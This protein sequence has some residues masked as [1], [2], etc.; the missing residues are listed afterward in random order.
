LPPYC[1]AKANSKGPDDPNFAKWRGT[2]GEAYTHIHHY[3]SGLYSEQKAGGTI[4]QHA[5]NRWLKGVVGEMAYVGRFCSAR[6]ALYPE[7]HT[8]WGWALG[9]QGQ[10]AEAIQHYQLA[11]KA[12]PKYTKAYAQMSD[13]Y[14]KINQPYTARKVI[15]TGL[16]AM[17]GS[18]MVQ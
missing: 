2:L 18:R 5:R 8:R 6:C 1:K 15:E 7:L 17:P 9:E 3:F 13:L 12:K 16:Q 11:I 4:D 14:V 10:L